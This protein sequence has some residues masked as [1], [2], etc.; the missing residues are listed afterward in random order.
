MHNLNNTLDP[1]RPGTC[2]RMYWRSTNPALPPPESHACLAR[3]PDCCV[4]GAV[5]DVRRVA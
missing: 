1:R 3:G 2:P 4:F 5:A